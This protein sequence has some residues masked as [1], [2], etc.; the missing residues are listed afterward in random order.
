MTMLIRLYFIALM[1]LINIH[2]V[3]SQQSAIAEV[4]RQFQTY[5][6]SDPDPIPVLTSNPKIY[7]YHRF[8]GYGHKPVQR[9][10]KVVTLENAQVQVFVL[11]EVG[12][13]VWGA[14][15]KHNG[16]EFIY[17]NEVMK[18]RNIAM[19]GPWTSGGIEF[20]FGIIGH[21]PAT[22]TPVDYLWRENPDGSV[23]CFVGNLDLPSRTYWRVEISLPPDKA[24]FETKALH[25]NSTPFTH[26]YYNWMTAAAVARQDLEFYTPGHLYLKHSGEAKPWPFDEKGRNLAKYR[27]NNFGPSKSYHVVGEYNDF[28]GGYYHDDHFGFGHWSRYDEMPGQ[29]L[30]IWALSRSGGIWED[31]LTDSDG[32]YIEFQAGRLFDQYS[33]EDHLNPITQAP[34]PSHTYDSWREIWFP[35]R[36]LGGITDASELGAMHM[37]TKDGQLETKVNSFQAMEARLVITKNGGE[38]ESRQI[39]LDPQKVFRHSMAVAKGDSIQ[40]MIPELKLAYDNYTVDTLA[41]PFEYPNIKSDSS[42]ASW[43]NSSMEALEYRQFQQALQGFQSVLDKDPHHLEARTQL[44]ALHFRRGETKQALKEVQFALGLDTYDPGA[45]YLA[46][47][48]YFEIK[49]WTNALESLGWAARSMEYRSA[50]YTQMA[51]VNLNLTEYH[52]ALHYAEKALK[53]NLE[54]ISALQAKTLAYQRL[55]MHQSAIETVDRILEI[56]PLNYFGNWEK[57]GEL[58]HILHNEFPHQ[59]YLELAMDYLSRGEPDKARILLEA[60]SSL[61][62]KIWLAWTEPKQTAESLKSLVAEPIRFVFPFRRETIPVLQWA[63]QQHDHWKFKYLLALNYWGKGREQEAFDLLQACDDLSDD[64]VF[65]ASRALL[66]EK[67]TGDPSLDDLEKALELDPDQWRHWSNLITYHQKQGNFQQQFNLASDAVKKWPDNYNLGLSRAQALL[68]QGDYLGSIQ[69]LAKL[70]ILPFEGASASR[71]I[72]QQAHILRA[73]QLI[74]KEDYLP[75]IEVLEAAKEWPEHLG[76]GKPYEPDHRQIDWLLAHCYA[77]VNKVKE[78][79]QLHQNIVHYSLSNPNSQPQGVLLGWLIAYGKGMTEE[80]E[81]LAEALKKY[82]HK[83]DNR[84]GR[85]AYLTTLEG[86]NDENEQLWRA[87]KQQ[88]PLEH[89][90]IEQLLSIIKF[91]K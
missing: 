40:L 48:I 60:S 47:N 82:Q 41:R 3:R 63:V 15:D 42:S 32:Q 58:G 56:D 14:I 9:E 70:N 2:P 17:R 65:Y 86:H 72:Y 43:Y 57:H 67:L 25:Y 55:G 84:W 37:V 80:T 39:S 35:V 36:E 89:K 61:I 18:F 46:G 22:A 5:P 53:F 7:P 13:K 34:F 6:F 8:D 59:S 45:N 44:A 74:D 79:E 28:F 49:D 66:Q 54:N 85:W 1:V 10:W 81:R 21:H 26:S 4:P 11:P 88:Q 90:I 69:Q 62:S 73:S 76:V 12:G 75:A 16:Q 24:Y 68:Y 38:A 78:A 51:M 83:E 87:L 31:L 52:D 33:P 30:W 64:G 19:R 23:S 77:K 20:N 91:N 50:A 71:A 27:E 29:K